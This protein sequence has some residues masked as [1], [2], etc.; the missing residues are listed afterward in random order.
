MFTG[1]ATENTPA[2]QV[3]DFSQAV[4]S[5]SSNRPFSLTDDCAPIQYI[6]TGGTSTAIDLYLPTCP[7][8]GKQIKII[9]A[10]FGTSQQV[11]NVRCSDNS[12]TGTGVV[13][14]KVGQSQTLDLCFSEHCITAGPGGSNYPT[15]WIALNESAA[16]SKAQGATTFG[17]NNAASAYCGFVGGGFGNTASGSACG[18]IAGNFNTASLANGF[19]AGGSSNTASGNNAAVIGGTTNTASG[20]NAAALASS[21][22]TVSGTASASIAS[23]SGA[24]PISGS[25]S[26]AIAT[27]SFSV[28]S[29]RSAILGGTAH[30]VSVADSA[31]IAGTNN[32]CSAGNCVVVGGTRNIANALQS[33][34]SGG[35]YGTTRSIIGNSVTPASNAPVASKAGATQSATLL[36]GRIT[37]DSTATRLTSDTNAASTTNQV[38]LPNN[39]AYYFRGSVIAYS[40]GG[41][42]KAWTFEGAIKRGATAASTAIVGTVILN[43][44]ASDPAGGF[45]GLTVTAD[46]TNGGLAVSGVGQFGIT[47]RWVCK[48]E[49]TEVVY[50]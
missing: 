30:T 33:I 3:W 47:V 9:N 35:A 32:S 12:S 5:S 6:K 46:T 11:I 29:D 50:A 39:S 25:N 43:V 28:T 37:T 44:T 4:A 26:V 17:D 15:G 38:I 49:T 42:A 41:D 22:A 36:L 19:V 45:F 31:V 14:Y 10:P 48:V 1:F 24:N 23:S 18:V 7:I 2:I 34:V 16:V 40:A 13:I 8:E 20:T 27:T 21:N